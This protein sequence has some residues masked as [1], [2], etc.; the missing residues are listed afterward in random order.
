MTAAAYA[1]SSSD[2]SSWVSQA[3]CRAADHSNS[4]GLDHGL[5]QATLAAAHEEHV[6]WPT[7][8]LVGHSYGALVFAQHPIGSPR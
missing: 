8:H 2:C 6:G 7:A 1:P 3:W 4:G 5:E